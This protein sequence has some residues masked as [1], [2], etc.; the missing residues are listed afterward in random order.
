M[1]P[2]IAAAV[3]AQD[4]FS[5]RPRGKLASMCRHRG[6]QVS[7]D[8]GATVLRRRLR[9]DVAARRADND[10][11]FVT[12]PPAADRDTAA[13][14]ALI[15]REVRGHFE[16]A[17]EPVTTRAIAHTAAPQP[18]GGPAVMQHLGCPL[19]NGLYG[20]PPATPDRETNR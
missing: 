19:S 18:A 20:P 15:D 16:G 17:S 4:Q 10:D 7:G 3:Q 5:G 6:L 1:P 8:D 13:R 14:M 9:A 11:R 12:P 2:A